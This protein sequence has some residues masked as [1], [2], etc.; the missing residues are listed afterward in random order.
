MSLAACIASLG[1][2]CFRQ[3]RPHQAKV[4]MDKSLDN[5]YY[6]AE[7]I[8]LFDDMLFLNVVRDPPRSG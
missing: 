8:T 6:A 2:C 4:V 5:V 3:V 1:K 7:L